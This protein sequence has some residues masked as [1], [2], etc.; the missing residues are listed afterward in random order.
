M[1]DNI[2]RECMLQGTAIITGK[3][4]ITTNYEKP[5]IARTLIEIP[6]TYTSDWQ[7]DGY[8]WHNEGGYDYDFERFEIKYPKEYEYL[9]NFGNWVEG[10]KRLVKDEDD[11]VYNVE[12]LEEVKVKHSI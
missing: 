12:E 6:A 8:T 9:D 11:K 3:E 10:N 7:C 1:Y 5:I 4:W 2:T